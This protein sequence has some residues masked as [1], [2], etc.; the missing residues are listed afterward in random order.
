MLD[1]T[2]VID[3]DNSL[4]KIDLFKETLGK[5]LLKQ[6]WVFLKTVLLAFKSRAA[7]KTFITKKSTTEWHT[8]PYN[9]KIFD[10]I[11]IYKQMGYKILLVTGAPKGYAHPIAS[12]LG[13]FDK[14]IATDEQINTTGANKLD[15]IINE[16]GDDFIYLGDSLKDLPVWLHC[17]KAILVGDNGYIKRKLK[18]NNVEIID[19]VKK[20]KS[21]IKIL[22]KQLRIHQWS[23]NLLLFVPALASHHLL[24]PGVFFNALTGFITFSLLASSIY[25]LN[26]IVDVDHDRKHP[27]KKNRPIAAGDLSMFS[28][29]AVLLACFLTGA[30]LAIGLGTTFLFVATGYIAL[31]LLYS[32]YLKKVIILDVILLMSFY[33]LRLIA[34][35][36]PDAI[37]LSSWLL[38]FS[39]FLFFSMG[40]LKRY[41]DTIVMR[42][43]N[44]SILSGRGYS[45]N[46]GNMLMSLGVGSGLVSALVLILYTGSEQVQ[47]FY[48]TPMLLVALAP[49]MLYWISRMWLMA[50]RGMI[51][52]DPVLF[53]I[54]DTHSYV[55]AFCFFSL[56]LISK[57]L[58]L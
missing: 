26:D 28:A 1:K 57:Y 45:I 55:V 37:P 23:K 36:M 14:V 7:A 15:A 35:H 2:L 49:V 20:G 47:Q 25:V 6:P 48:A 38:S 40:L 19:V 39:I 10:I 53:A 27:K 31:N 42:E 54:K 9:S 17:K 46:D 52:S 58:V 16:V 21:T 30:W 50:E 33:T 41:V 5:S 32:F 24:N 8:L 4:L 29:Y 11:T 22:F 44:V 56:M 18:K 34:G 12:H 3:L 51:K 13:L 43:N